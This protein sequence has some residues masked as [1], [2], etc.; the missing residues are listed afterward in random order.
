MNCIGYLAPDGTH[1]DCEAWGHSALARR[2]TGIAQRSL[3][4]VRDDGTLP[5]DAEQTLDRAGWVRIEKNDRDDHDAL[6]F[7]ATHYDRNARLTE[8]QR[9]W[10]VRHGY[11]KRLA[12][13]CGVGAFR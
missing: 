10:L 2:I 6:S 11:G 4:D 5:P 13:L 8:P 12:S 1:Y 3:D 9:A 7:G